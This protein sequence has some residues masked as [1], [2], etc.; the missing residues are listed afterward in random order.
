MLHP[1]DWQE[2]FH[3]GGEFGYM[4][5]IFLRGGYKF[6]YSQEGLNLGVGLNIAGA[7][8]DYSYSEFELFDIIN[9]ISVG[10]AF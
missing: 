2:Q 7:K 9:R 10:F 1:R 3:L 6:R 5:M 8:I 4:D